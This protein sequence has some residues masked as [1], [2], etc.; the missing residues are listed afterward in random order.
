MP[1]VGSTEIADVQVGAQD[2]QTLRGIELRPRSQATQGHGSFVTSIPDDLTIHVAA[3]HVSQRQANQEIQIPFDPKASVEEP[4]SFEHPCMEEPSVEHGGD[5]IEVVD[6][7]IRS[8]P[9]RE[10]QEPFASVRSLVEHDRISYN[11]IQA[12]AL[13]VGDPHGLERIWR[14]EVIVVEDPDKL[15]R[16]DPYPLVV[17]VVDS[18]VGLADDLEMRILAQPGRLCRLWMPHRQ[19]CVRSCRHSAVPS[20]S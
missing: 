7:Q 11:R 4:V 19:R 12:V 14:V 13:E 6:V 1:Q 3:L 2:L 16:C 10:R 9:L 15:P 17:G 8:L 18:N 5:P 20:H